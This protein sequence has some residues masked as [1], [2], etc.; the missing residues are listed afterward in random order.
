LYLLVYKALHGQAP[1]PSTLSKLDYTDLAS[2]LLMFIIHWEVNKSYTYRTWPHLFKIL[3]LIL[4]HAR[5]GYLVFVGV[6][7]N[8]I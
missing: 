4:L 1:E 6:R 5:S 3:C 7:S 8:V 2:D